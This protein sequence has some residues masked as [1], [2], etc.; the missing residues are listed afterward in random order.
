[1]NIVLTTT[2][3][4][5][6]T[7]SHREA[8]HPT[9]IRFYHAF[10]T[11]KELEM[12]WGIQRLKGVDEFLRKTVCPRAF[13]LRVRE[14]VAMLGKRFDKKYSGALSEQMKALVSQVVQDHKATSPAVVDEVVRKRFLAWAEMC[15][16]LQTLNVTFKCVDQVNLVIVQ[17]RNIQNAN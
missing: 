15:K 3:T 13:F 17:I 7:T 14:C 4:T 16:I 9:P 2:T 6:I 1:M 10:A 8:D 11:Q 5:V 12:L